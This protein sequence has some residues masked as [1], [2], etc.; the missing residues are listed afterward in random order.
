MPKALLAFNAVSKGDIWIAAQ[1][2]V[3][4]CWTHAYDALKA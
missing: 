4:Q 1:G 3:L 2:E